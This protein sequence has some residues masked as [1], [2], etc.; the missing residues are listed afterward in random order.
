MRIYNLDSIGADSLDIA[1]GKAKGL[2]ELFRC[3]LNAV[4][5][6][7]AI[8]IDGEINI[9]EAADH[10]E[11][12]GMGRVA[13]RSSATAEDGADFSSAGQYL[14]VLGVEGKQQVKKAI[15]QCIGSLSGETA[16]SYSSYFSDAKSEKMS[17]I[18]QQ[19]VDADVSGVCFTQHDG[20]DDFVHVE[21]VAGLGESLVSGQVQANTYIVQK[22]AQS[23]EG[24]EL[25]TAQLVQRIACEAVKA[26]EVL[27]MPLDLEW[28][29]AAGELYWLQARPITVTETID[30]FELDTIN[31]PDDHV[32]TTCNVGE[33]MP[34]AV[35]PLTLSTS[36]YSID[37]GMRKMFVTAG[38][39]KS[40]DDVAPW[41]GLVSVGNTLF[42][43]ITSTQCIVDNTLG[44]NRDAAAVSICGRVLED[45]PEQP[46]PRVNF[47]IKLVNTVKYFSMLMKTDRAC[48][49]LN[50]LAENFWIDQKSNSLNQYEEIDSKLPAM[51]E[52]FWIH[53][54]PSAHSGAMN[55]AIFFML[56]EE[57]LEPEEI[58]RRLAGALEDIDG[59]ESVDILRSLR[60]VAAEL[61]EENPGAVDYS[62]QELA[63]YLKVCEDDSAYALEHFM[64]RHGH[65]AIREAEL[66]SKSWHMDEIALCSYLK[67]IIASGTQEVKK[68]KPSGGN[69][70]ALLDGV[71]AK[72]QRILKVLV[73]QSRKGVV[74]REYSKS[75]CIKVVDRFKVAYWHLG[76]LMEK[77]ALLPDSDLVFFL[78][79]DEL[80]QLVRGNKGLVKKAVARRRLLD[81][82]MQLKFDEIC[83]GRPIPIEENY[84]LKD[85]DNLLLGT[86]ISRGK[87]TG[88][89]RV[90]KSVEDANKLEKGEI[91]V[92]AFTDIG[93]S[94]Y[95]SLIGALVTEVGSSLSHGA[96]VARE[97]AL[98]LVSNIPYATK[99]IKTGDTISVD[100]TSGKVAI[101]E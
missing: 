60:R 4:P 99:R 57:G 24:D 88:R 13:V 94:P 85:G 14:T 47:L 93:W 64:K 91:M 50:R 42:L 18:V 3:G 20:D 71:S 54:I 92:A 73:K 30:P 10:Y 55:S 34:G 56:T 5:G 40:M 98:P 29:A 69:I 37:Y 38:G 2:F 62:A 36:I 61:V 17:V 51:N 80:G 45:V 59:I 26:S 27:K 97:Y 96:V 43:D 28:A 78:K 49:K 23:A 16:N 84:S 21:A 52:A 86:S 53:Y 8:D 66:R 100:G 6:F 70:E 67:S 90:I 48:K 79:H 19:M 22:G 15:K 68:I 46:V 81:E 75:R 39:A 74:N 82:Q 58:N 25:L 72:L 44:G 83:V 87:A 1:G 9:Q 101:I 35:T 95:Y 32:V 41:S 31:I 11:K 63:E 33:M 65:R 12:S 77:E 89:A 7:V 76:S